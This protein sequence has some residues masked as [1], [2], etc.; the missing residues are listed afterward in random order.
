VAFLLAVTLILQS[1]I[2]DYLPSRFVTHAVRHRWLDG[3]RSETDLLRSCYESI[4]AC[5]DDITLRAYQLRL[6]RNVGSRD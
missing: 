6:Q 2:S 3:Q 4:F 1:D 5:F